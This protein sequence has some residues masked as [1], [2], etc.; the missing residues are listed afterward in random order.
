[1]LARAARRRARSARCARRGKYILIDL[2]D[3]RH[4]AAAS[5]H[6]RPD[7]RRRAA[8]APHA[9]HDHVVLT[10]DDGTVVRFNDARRFGLLDYMRRGEADAH[11]LLA[12][13]GPEPLGAGLRRRLSEPR[14]GRQD[15]ADQGG[16]ARPAHRRR[17]RQHLCLRGAV[18]RRAVAAPA[19]RR[20][21]PGRAPSG[22]STAIRDGADRGD[23][24]RRLVAA[25]LCPGR[26][27]ARL[28]PAS[29]GG[30]R[31]AR[32]SPAPSC[33][34]PSGVRRIVQAGRSTFFCAKKQR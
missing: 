25:R 29:L 20:R 6:V 1:M 24:G 11:P 18:P 21:W 31:Q 9:P 26:W 13:M 34:A 10:L 4:A 2:D 19:R 17:A 3:E 5:R 27:R 16:A 23:R 14:A 32:A 7:H 30:L 28:F 8:D 12:G 22:S 33:T 15:D